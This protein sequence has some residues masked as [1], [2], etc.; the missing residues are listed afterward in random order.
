[1]VTAFCCDRVW[2]WVASGQFVVMMD[3]ARL[4]QGGLLTCSSSA[5]L[6]VRAGCSSNPGSTHWMPALPHPYTVTASTVPGFC[7]WLLMGQS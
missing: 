3:E 1:M 2:Q 6:M 4:G 5:V 7:K